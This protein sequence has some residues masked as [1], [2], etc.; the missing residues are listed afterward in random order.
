MCLD[1]FEGVSYINVFPVGETS[2]SRCCQTRK[3][4][5]LKMRAGYEQDFQE[6]QDFTRLGLWRAGAVVAGHGVFDASASI[7]VVNRD[8]RVNPASDDLHGEGQA[9]AL[10]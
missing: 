7:I 6:F 8:N 10:R 3:L 5:R 2:W 4:Q 9:L 1:L